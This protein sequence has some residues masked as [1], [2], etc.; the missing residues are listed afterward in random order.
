MRRLKKAEDIA[1]KLFALIMLG[2]DRNISA[3]HVM[4]EEA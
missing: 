1:E 4:G 2:D 3:T